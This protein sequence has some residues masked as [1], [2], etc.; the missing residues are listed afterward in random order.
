MVTQGF[1]LLCLAT[2]VL[3][4]T[5]SHLSLGSSALTGA[6]GSALLMFIIIGVVAIIVI[7]VVIYCIFKQPSYRDAYT[8][9]GEYMPG[10]GQ[11]GTAY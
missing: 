4:L 9:G 5:T 6:D 10:Q 7:G 11:G 1:L 8:R 3:S 2:Q